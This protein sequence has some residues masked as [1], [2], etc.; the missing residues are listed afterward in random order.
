MRIS[1]SVEYQL[2]RPRP[3]MLRLPTALTSSMLPDLTLSRSL[4]GS[5][6]GMG[7]LAAATFASFLA[8]L[9]SLEVLALE[10]SSLDGFVDWADGSVDVA[11]GFA[12]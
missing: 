6:M 9:L 8:V 3:P 5:A 11:A 7:W 1:Q 4:P 10:V 2:P 12:F